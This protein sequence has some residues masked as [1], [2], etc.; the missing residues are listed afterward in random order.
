VDARV[1]IIT[2]TKDRP[3]LL[4]R[5]LESVV[6]QSFD[7][8]IMVIINDGGDPNSVNALVD[9][10]L[11]QARGKIRVLH[12]QFS[13]GM[14]AASN[15]G[16][17]SIHTE[18]LAIHDDDDS[19][20]PEFLTICGAELDLIRRQF[21]LVGAVICK[22]NAVFERMDGNTVTVESV[23]QYKP[24]LK[25]GFLPLDDMIVENQFS[26]IQML[27]SYEAAKSVGFFREDLPVLGDWDF[28][29]KLMK[30][31]DIYVVP[32]VLAFYHHRVGDQT[33]YSNSIFASR[34]RHEQYAQMLRNEWLRNDIASASVGLGTFGNL[35][36][37]IQ[38]ALWAEDDLRNALQHVQNAVGDLG[39]RLGEASNRIDDLSNRSIRSATRHPVRNVFRLVRLWLQSG[40]ALHYVAQTLRYLVSH[41]PTATADRVRA[42]MHSRRDAARTAHPSKGPLGKL[43][44]RLRRW[45][46]IHRSN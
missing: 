39:H 26:P 7:D 4:K 42:W 43:V 6:Y 14:E 28:N 21:P 40:A 20:A 18:Y 19:W 23:E 31:H 27:F 37:A 38:R 46:R 30:K 41:G 12:N 9:A 2:R 1:G 5:A 36:F 16:I 34:S 17:A 32:Q 33:I 13:M 15:R 3:A 10:F 44:E 24:W 45:L 22:A 25:A 29:I 8:W 35:R 11:P